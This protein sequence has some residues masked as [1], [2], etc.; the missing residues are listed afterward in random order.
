MPLNKE[1][2]KVLVIGS[3]PII[4]GQAAEFDYA[5]TQACLALKE[6][7]LN[8]VL[9]NS[10]PATIMTD[11]NMADKVYIE[12]LTLEI[13]KNIIKKEK[14]DSLLATLGGQIA[15]NL[16][17][18]LAEDGILDEM[19]IKVLG[20]NIDSITKAEDRYIFKETMEKINEPCVESKVVGTFSQ[21]INYVQSIGLPVVL[22]PA[23]T[24]GGTGGGL[25]YTKEDFNKTLEAGL[26]ASRVHQ[27]LIEK[28]IYGW[29]E[30]E[31]EVVRD[32]LG[33]KVIVCGMENVDPVGIHTGDSIVV[34]PIQTLSKEDETMLRHSALNIA[35][36][37]KITGGCNVQLAL[38]P[39]SH[40]YAVIEVNPRLSRSS[41]L[42]SKA[43]GF[44]IARIA[45]KIAVGYTFDELAK[46]DSTIDYVVVKFPRFPFDKFTD[47]NRTLGTQMKATG[48]IMTLADTLEAGF[49]KAVKSLELNVSHLYMPKLEE[50]TDD[51]LEQKLKLVDDERFFALCESISRGISLEKLHKTTMIDM[52]FLKCFKNLID[53]KTE[54]KKG[55]T[56]ELL[57]KA[58]KY[59][60]LDRTISHICNITEDEVNK[61]RKE[62]SI[63]P[64][65]KEI[66]TYNGK[67]IAPRPYYYSIWTN[68]IKQANNS[69]NKKVV[70]LG[71]GPIRIGQGIEFDYCSVHSV[72][73]LKELGYETIIINNNPETVSTDF[74]TSDKLYFEP[75]TLEDV[76]NVIDY[77][78][79]VG[80]IVG[81]GGQTAIKLCDKLKSLGVKILGTAPETVDA[82]EDRKLFDAILENCKIKKP[83]A[84]TVFTHDE[85]LVAANE[86]GYP[87][88][89]RPSYVLGGFGMGIAYNNKDVTKFIKKINQVKQKHPILVDKYVMGKEIEVDVICDGE[90]VFIPGIMENIERTGVHSGDSI[91]VYPTQS[92]SPKTKEM[93]I[94][95]TVKLAHALK[96]VGLMNIQFIATENDLYVIEVNPRSSRTVPFLSKATDI[97]IVNV[98]TKCIMGKKL[99]ELGYLSLTPKEPNKVF[100]KV[101]VFS[102]QKLAGVDICLAP[103]MK[104]TGEV[105]G[106]GK[107]YGEALFKGF[108]G[109]NI[110]PRV[111][112]NVLFSVRDDDKPEAVNIAKTFKEFGYNILATEHTAKFLE[113]FGIS[114]VTVSKQEQNSND[115]L[116]LIQDKNI[117]FIINTPINEENIR[118]SE[119]KIRQCATEHGIPCFTSIDTAN[120]IVQTLNSE[121]IDIEVFSI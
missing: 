121:E 52:F 45:T 59:G 114:S 55:L 20:T 72:W 13:V 92:V 6:E 94:D 9:I 112:K 19:G 54:L 87:V 56:P 25:V 67:E 3:G 33:N 95:Y 39:E 61:M 1:I 115:I 26:E 24:M 97:P 105:L 116:T 57:L 113:K 109:A 73:A 48:E 14:P 47:G 44:P 62:N 31:Y 117:S 118:G 8:V 79:P 99:K 75:L 107:N 86:L 93:V 76:K 100:V 46:Y 102:F 63:V 84:R 83:D 41:A 110:K 85:A 32:R 7:G 50:L 49:I 60:Y 58:K 36:E 27:V 28:C 70:V 78:N 53:V 10:N 96:I 80:I 88:L 89:V 15:L 38:N 12:P 111:Q 98:A 5:G 2:K 103:E 35:E 16:S 34:S 81:F 106:I 74:D 119:L 68:D 23:Y 37:L 120:A 101:P 65:Y 71:S 104:S 69:T 82:C 22:R 51:E 90:D 43:T 66:K 11:K 64:I 91:S 108:L 40:E 18:E 77:E 21:G 30:I 4:I 29:K 17:I 42:A